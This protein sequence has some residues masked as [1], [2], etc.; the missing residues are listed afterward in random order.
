MYIL[1]KLI[2]IVY[3]LYIPH[4]KLFM[5]NLKKILEK[6]IR[7]FTLIKTTYNLSII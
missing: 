3:R 4:M 1:N 7:Y 2:L 6:E 5:Q